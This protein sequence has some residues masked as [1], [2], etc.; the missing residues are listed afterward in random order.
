MALTLYEQVS[1]KRDV[2]KEGL[3]A[4]DVATLV[5]I[6]PGPPGQPQGA[7]LEVFNALGQ[8]IC[9]TAVSVEDVEPLRADEILAV[10]TLAKAS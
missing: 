8:T 4:N 2:P 6:V 9:V 1:L 5:E 10:R 7:L 3:R